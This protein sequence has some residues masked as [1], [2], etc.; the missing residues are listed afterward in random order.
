MALFKN[1]IP[2]DEFI[3]YFLA[4]LLSKSTDLKDQIANADN[5]NILSSDEID[6]LA[7]S[8]Y[9]LSITIFTDELLNLNE[10]GKIPQYKG[11]SADK[12]SHIIAKDVSV[13]LRNVYE[14]NRIP[15]SEYQT[16][17]DNITNFMDMLGHESPQVL[18]KGADFAA[19]QLVSKYT[20]G[21]FDLTQDSQRDKSFFCFSMAM[22]ICKNTQ[23]AIKQM[24]KDYR[25]I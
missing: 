19:T 17:I 9:I 20:F 18:E 25:I 24:A 1:K 16:L 6:A 3:G 22:Q 12:A 4:G 2:Y 7:S 5:D 15:D 10:R 14:D 8:L 11:L 23:S 21:K 13:M